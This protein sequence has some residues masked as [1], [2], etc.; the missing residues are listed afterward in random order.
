[1]TWARGHAFTLYTAALVAVM[2]LGLWGF[3]RASVE[4]AHDAWRAD[5]STCERTNESRRVLR[6]YITAATADP[7]PRQYA[8]ITDQALR[9][10][11]LEQARRSRATMRADAARVFAPIDC[12]TLYPEP[13]G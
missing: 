5:L 10:G 3:N 4:R 12:P 11:A 13:R 9:D 2:A 8:F 7:D 6:D 1:M